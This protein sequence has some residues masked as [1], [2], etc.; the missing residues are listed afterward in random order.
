MS[1]EPGSLDVRQRFHR[2]MNYETIDR[3]PVWF[4]GTWAETQ[5]R[6]RQEG[7]SRVETI[8]AET[9]MDPDWEDD[10]WQIHGLLNV[11]PI[12][13]Y[14]EEVVEET[15][16]Y[17]VIRTALGAVEKVPRHGSSIHQHMTHALLPT[18]ESWKRFKTM[19]DP[20]DARRRPA[21]WENAARAFNRQNRFKS[22]LGGS[23]FGLP[24]DWMG[25][26]AIS[27]LPYDDPVLFEAIIEHMTDS[28][29]ALTGPLLDLVEFD[30]AYVFEDCCFNTGPLFSPDT[31]RR[32]YAKYY[33]KLVDFY[34]A[35]GVRAIL[36]DSD[37][38]VDD[39]IPCW[40]DSGIDIIFPIEVGTWGA[41][42]IDLRRR[43]GP[44]LRMMGGFN[45]HLIP[46]GAPAI[47]TELERLKPLVESGGYIPLPDHRIPPDC[48]LDAFRCYVDTYKAVLCNGVL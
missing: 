14:R 11:F 22:F 25:V 2:L 28:F 21:G 12:G 43:F 34:H 29:M 13:A 42:P 15:D 18:R 48:S 35:K 24:R 23:L 32:F 44:S 46:Q 6:W 37:G 1:G 9:G 20:D 26:E 41:D 8:P 36:L 31:F 27:C 19:I 39:L 47:R 30:L 7:L 16:D 3:P 4:F 5:T 38:K 45:K 10:L 33:R 40:L 17:R